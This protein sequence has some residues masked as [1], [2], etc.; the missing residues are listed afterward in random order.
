MHPVYKDDASTFH[1]GQVIQHLQP[2]VHRLLKHG[3]AIFQCLRLNTDILPCPEV[4]GK[5]PLRHLEIEIG[6]RSMAQLNNIIAALG[7][8]TMLEY[9]HISANGHTSEIQVSLPDLC[10]YKASNLKHVHLQ[11]C[12]PQGK[13][14]LPMGCQLR[15]NQVWTCSGWESK[16]QSE[17]GRD[18]L[19]CIPALC[20]GFGYGHGSFTPSFFRDFK[21]L[22]Y[23]QLVHTPDLTDLAILQG[24]PHVEIRKSKG[25]ILHSA[26][27][28][29]SIQIKSMHAYHIVFADIDA[30]V[31]ENLKYL[32]QTYKATKEWRSMI[33]ALQSASQK[34]GVACFS[35]TH[36]DAFKWI[37]P[38]PN[39]ADIR[40]V[41]LEDGFSPTDNVVPMEKI[42]PKQSMQSCLTSPAPI[43][44]ADVL[45]CKCILRVSSTKLDQAD[46]AGQKAFG[47]AQG[48]WRICQSQC[49][50]WSEIA[51]ILL[52]CVVAMVLAGRH[53]S[54]E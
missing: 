43:C 32:F 49:M 46:N 33:S 50:E 35:N 25:P 37:S 52:L 4:L 39:V 38:I 19:G 8:C 45:E 24:I 47:V 51:C 17:N 9:L 48:G 26:G 12:F 36:D 1:V 29:Q 11:A 13:L 3:S 42:W 22:Q 18:L 15:L 30:F 40:D 2:L 20:M 10:L 23:L 28:W 14:C 5:L 31:R 21:V 44:K 16:W 41:F 7:Q 54:L 53:A 27:S 34:Q 6:Q